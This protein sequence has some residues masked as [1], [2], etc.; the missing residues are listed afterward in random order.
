MVKPLK[1]EDAL[2]CGSEELV[3]SRMIKV[4][5][6]L[7]KYGLLRLEIK[8]EYAGK[9]LIDKRE[10]PLS[11]DKRTRLFFNATAL[12]TKEPLPP[13]EKEL[14]LQVR[15][16]ICEKLEAVDMTDSIP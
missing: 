3:K 16:V 14:R 12:A 11:R 2:F 6:P 1:D 7:T 15:K 9:I 8:D 10:H 13:G 4:E 5:K